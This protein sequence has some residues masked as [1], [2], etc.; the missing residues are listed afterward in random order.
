MAAHHRAIARL[1]E[2]GRTASGANRQPKKQHD[3]PQALRY[4]LGVVAGT[5]IVLGLIAMVVGVELHP[6]RELAAAD[7]AFA[8]GCLVAA[9]QPR[10]AL[11]IWPVAAALLALIIG[12]GIFD[13]LRGVAGPLSES[14]HA[15]EIAGAVILGVLARQ[16]SRNQPI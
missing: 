14:H 12:T 1:R 6:V 4:V 16:T 5:E 11:G 8:V 9:V 15:L 7:F 10:R 13:L 2:V 3:R